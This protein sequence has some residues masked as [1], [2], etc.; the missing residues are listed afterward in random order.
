MSKNKSYLCYDIIKHGFH[1]LAVFD[2]LNPRNPC[3]KLITY[4]CFWHAL[5][6]YCNLIEPKNHFDCSNCS[7]LVGWS[8]TS[9]GPK[10]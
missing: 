9:V 2:E 6:L 3:L 1:E 10:Y 8:Q 4:R 5:M 7:V